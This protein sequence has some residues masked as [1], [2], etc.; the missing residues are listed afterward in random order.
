MCI[1]YHHILHCFISQLSIAS[2]THITLLM[3]SGAL[4]RRQPSEA[5]ADY[6]LTSA[7]HPRPHTPTLARPTRHEKTMVLCYKDLST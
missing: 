5:A 1:L 2:K 4:A 7:A 6:S 3:T